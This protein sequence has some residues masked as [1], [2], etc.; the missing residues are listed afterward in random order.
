MRS[1]LMIR[2]ISR[3]PG[4]K[5]FK[6][7]YTPPGIYWS[8]SAKKTTVAVAATAWNRT[9][10]NHN[11]KDTFPHSV[12]TPSLGH[13]HLLEYRDHHQK[14]RIAMARINVKGVVLGGLLAGPI[15]NIGETIL[16]I[17]VLGAQLEAAMKA[18]NL[19]PV[20]MGPVVVFLIGGFVLGLILV[21][22]YAAIRPRFGAG[23]K[24]SM[25]AAIVLWFLAYFWPSLGMGLMGFMPMK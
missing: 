24:T 10:K 25:M 3:S 17:P 14:G 1:P 2:S 22:L 19:P 7:Y 9:R 6:W 21:W 13:L 18:L 15:I 12:C 23:P 20:G 5:N 8:S 11:S 4:P 16:N